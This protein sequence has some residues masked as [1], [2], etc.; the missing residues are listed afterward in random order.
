MSGA[1]R[2]ILPDALRSML[3]AID[4]RGLTPAPSGLTIGEHADGSGRWHIIATCI[5][6]AL[7]ERTLRL[8]I[9]ERGACSEIVELDR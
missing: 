2:R 4:A 3:N 8:L 1:Q 7:D 5:D 9:D 6:V